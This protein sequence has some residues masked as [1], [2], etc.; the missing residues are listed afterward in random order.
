MNEVSDANLVAQTRAGDTRAFGELVTRYENTARVV[1]LRYARHHHSAEDTVQQAF[2]IAF[3]QLAMLSDPTRFSSWLM[4]IVQREAMQQQ[5][6]RFATT[7]DSEV[8]EVAREDGELS[9]DMEQAVLLL[10]QLPE[11]ERIV[12]SLHFLDGHSTPEIASMI[13]KPL[14]TVTKQ[15]SRA[16]Q[17]I[18]SLA[19]R[20][21][22]K[23][24]HRR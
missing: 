4:R 11:H 17:R 1:A 19:K 9:D 2:L 6:R 7:A 20:Q 18:Q 15:L 21:E 13:A 12:M 24:E 3:E 22:R 5:R 14:G 16:T 23:H 10:N 8:I